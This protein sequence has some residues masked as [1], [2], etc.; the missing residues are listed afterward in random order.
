MR[1]R[2]GGSSPKFLGD[3]GGSGDYGW[4][5]ALFIRLKNGKTLEIPG[6][7]YAR[8]D[9]EKILLDWQKRYNPPES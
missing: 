2:G 9:I 6:S 4:Y 5:T 7:P 3:L 1:S 8:T